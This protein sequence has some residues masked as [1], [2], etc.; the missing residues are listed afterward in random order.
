MNCF[1]RYIIAFVCLIGF[2]HQTVKA[3]TSQGQITQADSRDSNL[4]VDSATENAG[5]KGT[6]VEE[7]DLISE[8]EEPG[9]QPSNYGV[10]GIPAINYNQDN[11]FGLGVIAK[12]YRYDHLAEPYKAAVTLQLFATTKLL[13]SHEIEIDV[14]DVFSFP[15]RLNGRFGI[16]SSLSQNFCG[17]GNSVTCDEDQ[18]T[19]AAL[20]AGNRD[21]GSIHQF[22]KKYYLTRFIRP[23]SIMNMRW[24][25][26]DLPHK[27]ELTA[28]WRGFYYQSGE[29]FD[30]DG[31]GGPDLYPY[32]GSHYTNYHRKGEN[33]FA[34]VLQAGIMI[35]NRDSEAAPKKG[36][37]LEGS[38]RGSAFPWGSSWNYAGYNATARTYMPLLAS[39]KLVIANRF[40]A[41]GIYGDAPVQEMIRVGGS[42]DYTAFGG[43]EMGRGIR[44]QRFVGRIKFMNQTELRHD[45]ASWR[46]LFDELDYKLTGVA[47]LDLGYI[48][49][50]WMDF[51]GDPLHVNSGFGFGGRLSL[52]G[53]FIVR[54]DV[55]T[56]PEENNDLSVYV[57]VGNLF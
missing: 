45:I 18:A 10:I 41:D 20:A 56:S 31:D 46:G 49:Y 57:N 14:L 39:R 2:N 1:S 35:D 27:V 22:Q 28:G 8:R 11:G 32:P 37:W 17:Y 29:F 48:G 44:V 55:A 42:K 24:K 33:G 34:S 54:V 26:W 36:Y 23:Y 12:A 4:N 43:E 50:D 21:P 52:G 38:I 13:Q 47:F 15:I 30:R 53:D 6:L 3:Q 51:G 5:P 16:Y 9:S 25:L 40:I 7:K 19:D